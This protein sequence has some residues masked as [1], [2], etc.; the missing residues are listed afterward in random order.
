MYYVYILQCNDSYYVGITQ[1][2]KERMFNHKNKHSIYTK[3][4]TVQMS[5][6]AEAFATPLASEMLAQEAINIC[7]THE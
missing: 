1:H 7:L 4:R 6:K 5:E 3:D 2:I